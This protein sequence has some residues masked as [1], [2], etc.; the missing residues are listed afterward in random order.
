MKKQ[1]IRDGDLLLAVIVKSEDWEKGVNFI[2]TDQDYQ[3]VGFWGYD[4]GKKLLRHIH[5]NVVRE[6][7]RTQEILCVE[8]GRLRADIY[9]EEKKYLRSVE[10]GKGDVIVVLSGGHGYEILEDNT[11]VMEVKN[12]PYVETDKDRE[13]IR[14][15]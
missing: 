12:G 6:V 2:S 15:E 14:L 13:R 11:K 3:Q 4:R 5:L 1:E 9:T 10:L 8:K 7:H